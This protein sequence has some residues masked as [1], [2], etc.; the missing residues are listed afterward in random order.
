MQIQLLEVLD[1]LPPSRQAE[2]LDFALFLRERQQ[3][4][5]W[6]A[7]SD[8]EAS[9]LRSE[10]AEEDLALAE[11]VMEDYLAQLQREDTA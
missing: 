10:F 2:V 8:E 5:R 11:A 3:S 9:M 6:D 4:Q 1:T 7:I